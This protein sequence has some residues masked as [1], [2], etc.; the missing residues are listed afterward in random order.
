MEKRQARRYPQGAVEA[1]FPLGGIGT[2][3]VSLEARGSLTDWEIENRPAKGHRIPHTFFSIRTGQPG[4]VPKAKVIEAPFQPPHAFSIGYH[5]DRVP[6]LPR[7]AAS[8][9]QVEYPFASVDFEDDDL[10]VEVRLEA[11]NPFIPLEADDS[12]IPAILFRYRVR[13][14]TEASVEVSVAGT[15]RNIIGQSTAF[16][17][18]LANEF[19]QEEEISGIHFVNPSIPQDDLAFGSMALMTTGR[20]ITARTEWLA[21]G[22]AGWDGL[23][24]FW[25]DFLEDGRLDPAPRFRPAGASAW[26]EFKV[27]SLACSATLLA[28]QETSFEFILAWHFPN[29]PR[30]WTECGCQGSEGCGKGR[31]VRNQYAVRFRDAWEAGRHLVRHLDRLESLSR[32]FSRALHDS[33]LPD[34]A[35]EAIAANIAVLRSNTCFRIE[36][37]ALL[38]FEGCLDER[39]CCPGNCT[40]VWNY[41]QTVAF[42]F[43]VLEQSMRRIEFG[44][45]T[46]EEGYME[47]RTNRVFGDD[48]PKL[49]KQ[50]ATDGQM[51]AIIRLYREWKISGDGSLVTD[52]WDKA[53]K[54]M[55]YA[56]RHWDTDG[57]FVLDSVQHNTYDIEFIGPGSLTNS[58]FFGAL[59]A[60][61]EMGDFTGDAAFAEAC[62]QA[63]RAGSE[64]MDRMLWNGEYYAQKL[65]D[66]DCRPYQYGTGCLSDQVFGQFLC[67]VAGLGRILPEDH[68]KKALESVYRYNF[69]QGFRDHFCAFRVYA[70]E[71]ES[72]LLT[73]SWPHGGRPK[74]PFIY[75]DEVWTGIEYQVAAHLVYEGFVDE[76]L[77]VAKAVRDRHDGYR[78]NPWNEVECGHHYVRAMSSW[79]LLTAL[80]GFSC[81]MAAGTLSFDPPFHPEDFSCFW[82]T[83][84]AW[85][86]YSQTLDPATGRRDWDLRVLYGDPGDLV[87]NGE[88]MD[89]GH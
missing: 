51:G 83:G 12:G 39:G 84:R 43:P 11:F 67:H 8:S 65:D 37:G 35:I 10:P 60:C 62:R 18:G 28:G 53:R 87:V 24:E 74:L 19:V 59:K 81:D 40:H 32:L 72:G 61:A 30:G 71:D 85:G 14:R 68:V 70:L 46:D 44:L 78:R 47:F 76:G 27:A 3:T 45:E 52:L 54:A 77:A 6:G 17:A 48:M 80:S 49:M 69:K 50:P 36:T 1:K 26:N 23:P 33:T 34:F 22:F 56:L 5:P 29:R 66:V 89:H 7:F 63:L 25:A 20:D 9:L 38:G 31:I 75:A 88:R 79:A 21:T 58:I 82:S 64:A 16:S 86:T 13:N 42:L 2:G 41:A 57:D 55:E 4:R 73:C 15:L